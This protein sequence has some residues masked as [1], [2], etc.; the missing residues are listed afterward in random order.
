MISEAEFNDVVNITVQDG[1]VLTGR[2]TVPVSSKA[3]I[4][5]S[6]GG[7]SSHLSPRNQYVAEILQKE[8]FA[9]LLVDLLTPE[10]NKDDARRTDIDNLAQRLVT[11]TDWVDQNPYTEA[12]YVGLVGTSSG[13]AAALQAV[14]QTEE[15]IDSL[16][17]R[18]GRLKL[19]EEKLPEVDIPVLLLVGSL[20]TEIIQENKDALTQLPGGSE[21]KIIEGASHDFEE[22][23]KLEE[24]GEIAR[25]WFLKT[26]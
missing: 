3:I 9:T 12:L 1:T 19:I 10:E 2:L 23:G 25:D 17:A 20:D 22:P 24:V 7:G 13:A 26:I 16:V 5:F 4:I 11:I 18:G 6:H 8:R 15:K 14:A 21:L